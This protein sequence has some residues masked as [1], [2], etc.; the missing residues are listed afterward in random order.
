MH[1]RLFLIGVILRVQILLS[2]FE[3]MQRKTGKP[4]KEKAASVG[5]L[6]NLV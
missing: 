1:A 6:L 2:S 3:W 5:D 4:Q